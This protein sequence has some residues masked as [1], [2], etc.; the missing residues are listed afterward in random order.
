M[1][2]ILTWSHYADSKKRSY[3]LVIIRRSLLSTHQTAPILQTLCKAHLL[4][5]TREG[6]RDW[7]PKY[8]WIDTGR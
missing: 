8:S 6:K 7:V 5:D 1:M 2:T 3:D 4:Q